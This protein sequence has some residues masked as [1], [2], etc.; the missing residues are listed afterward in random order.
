MTGFLRE[1]NA[2]ENEFGQ[3]KLDL[4]LGG[5]STT[6][7]KLTYAATTTNKCCFLEYFG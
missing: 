4:D 7:N 1:K 6:T 2:Q 5:K 3:Q